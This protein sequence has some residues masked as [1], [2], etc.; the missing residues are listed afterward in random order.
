MKIISRIKRQLF[1]GYFRI[2]AVIHVRHWRGHGIHSP[3]MYGIVRNVFMKSRITGRDRTLYN[4]LIRH[5]IGRK[6]G[7]LLQNLYTHCKMERFVLVGAMDVPLPPGPV[8]LHP[9]AEH[10]D[11]NIGF[12]GPQ[13]FGAVGLSG[14]ARTAPLVAQMESRT[15]D[16]ATLPLRQRGPEGHDAVFCRSETATATLPDIKLPPGQT[17]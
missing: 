13:N 15:A 11:R 6:N 17:A 4:A 10:N 12:Y 1:R 8:F 2:G 16:P 3:F 7:I 14:S 5:R 9:A